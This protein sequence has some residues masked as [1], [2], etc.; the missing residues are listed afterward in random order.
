[1]EKKQTLHSTATFK[2]WIIHTNQ[3][4][5]NHLLKLYITTL[6]LTVRQNNNNKE[7]TS[8]HSYKC[9]KLISSPFNQLHWNKSKDSKSNSNKKLNKR[10]CFN[11]SFKRLKWIMRVRRRDWKMCRWSIFWKRRI[12]CLN[13]RLKSNCKLTE[14]L[15]KTRLLHKLYTIIVR[16]IHIN[17]QNF[18]KINTKT[19]NKMTLFQS[20]Q[21]KTV[22]MTQKKNPPFSP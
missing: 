22:I 11:N 2:K 1:M 3:P 20:T 21:L 5:Y 4:I 7:M 12:I 18:N 6:T 14:I 17:T 10:K 8:H 19:I 9:S 16:I 15:L 13:L